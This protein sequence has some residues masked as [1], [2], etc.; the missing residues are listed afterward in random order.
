[1]KRVSLSRHHHGALHQD[2]KFPID[3]IGDDETC[4]NDTTLYFYI[5]KGEF[6]SA[7]NEQFNSSKLN[8]IDNVKISVHGIFVNTHH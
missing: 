2:L 5:I 4:R 1:L 8:G 7:T 3:G 6:V